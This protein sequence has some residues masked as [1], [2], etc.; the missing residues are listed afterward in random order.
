[1]NRDGNMW[2]YDCTFIGNESDGGTNYLGQQGMGSGG[3]IKNTKGSMVLDGCTIANNKARKK[4]GAIKNSCLGTLTMM[5][6]TVTGNSCASGG[7]HLNGPALIDHCTIALNTAPYS[8]G[9]GILINSES[10]IRNTIVYGNTRGDVVVDWEDNGHLAQFINLWIGDGRTEIGTFAGDPL[11]SPFGDYGGAT[12]TFLLQ[13]ESG[14]IDA[15]I[16]S[17]SSPLVDQRGFPR[18]CGAGPDIGAIEIE[19]TD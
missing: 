5:N 10:I 7:I 15:A 17:D 6:C 12:W 19:P 11:L 2:A 3:A 1:M 9:A 8:L 18:A 16:V 13:A 4:G 14:A